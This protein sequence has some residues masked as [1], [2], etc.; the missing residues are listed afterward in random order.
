M[1]RSS[2]VVLGA[3]VLAVQAAAQEPAKIA[4]ETYRLANGLTVILA[5]QRNG[6]Q[7]VAVDVWYDVG[8]RNEVRGR[9]GFAHLFEHMMFQGSANVKK[10]EFL[11]LVQR[12]GGSLNGSTADDRTNY[13]ETLPSN[14][15][16]LGLWLE[17]DR[18]RS[19]A[20]TPDNLDNQ[21]E[22][23][24]EER[25]LRVDNQPYVAAIVDGLTA[26]YDSTS[27]FPYAHNTI[28]SMAD[29]DAARFEDVKAFHDLY[30]KPNNAIL[31]VVGD[32]DPAEAKQLIQQYFGSIPRG[33][34]PPPVVCEARFSTGQLRQRF[35]DPKATLP[36]VVHAFRI[37]PVADA[38]YPALELLATIIG[39]GES[40]RFNRVLARERKAAVA[41]QAAA[42][43]FGPRRGPGVFF[44]LA[45]ANQGVSIDSLDALL[46]AEIAKV[47]TD[48]VT[49]EELTKARNQYRAQII[50]RRQRAFFVAEE[51]QAAHM[52]G[53]TPE[54]IN[55]ALDRYMAVTV[56]DIKRVAARYLVPANSLILIVTAEAAS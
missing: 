30:Y 29:L 39:Q 53:G 25:R 44:A 49:D 4:V 42:N 15:L 43:P 19:L 38:D 7:V 22:V 11:Q 9:S 21:R 40:S 12:A 18:M 8:S 37:P 54:A 46:A 17:A 32:F 50:D 41:A 5:P 36:A 3:L 6:A 27:C 1:Q 28:G 47:A 10:G 55:T 34:T 33:E 26:L 52:F 31:T 23:V 20:V 45:V 48:G 16:N 2:V 24:K 13:Y 35:A 51:L 14:R 56:D